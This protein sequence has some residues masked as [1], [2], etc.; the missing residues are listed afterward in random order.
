M[1]FFK[2]CL[3]FFSGLLFSTNVL[4]HENECK[5]IE[6]PIVFDQYGLPTIELIIN[7]K[8]NFA[9]LDLGSIAGIHL[10]ISDISSMP[11]VKYTG[12]I[13]KSTNIS[14]EIFSDKEFIIP[15]LAIE[16][17]TFENIS[18]YELN[19][20]A[21]SIGDKP[22]DMENNQQIVIGQGFFADKTIIINYANKKL[23][24]NNKTGAVLSRINNKF[25]PYVL[26]EEGITIQM[27]SSI[28]N[29][30]MVLDT[31]ATSSI[32]SANKINIKEPLTAC[33]FN[34][35]LDVK[36]ELFASTVKIAGYSFAS[37]ILLYPIDPRFTKDGLL[38]G[39][40]FNQ[41]IVE[42]DFSNK[43]I[44]LA[45]SKPSVL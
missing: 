4:S 31:G 20:W 6:V 23:I 21:T 43:N 13:S 26:N 33:N 41:F 7:G 5:E 10:P 22:E 34:L 27:S 37:N 29:Y 39:D 9:L 35:G 19:P 17:M 3:L 38:G 40:F 30:Q 25:I 16:C 18:G 11:G 24:I 8:S 1:T 32:F 28:A 36:C 14:G 12:E 42:L 15:M 44:A 45:P 2:F